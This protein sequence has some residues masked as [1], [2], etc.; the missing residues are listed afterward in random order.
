MHEN[1]HHPVIDDSR[2]LSCFTFELTV[3]L[4]S[5]LRVLGVVP[6]GLY[7]EHTLQKKGPV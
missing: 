2:E 4:F 1:Q 3:Q 7:S 6:S 5:L